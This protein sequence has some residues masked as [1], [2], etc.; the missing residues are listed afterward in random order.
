MQR[1]LIAMAVSIICASAAHA[2]MLTAVVKD[3]DGAPKIIGY[4]FGSDRQ[5]C[6]AA[7]EAIKKMQS[8]AVIVQPCT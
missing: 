3:K 7:M 1:L 5:A 4:G 8:E 2:F 6:I